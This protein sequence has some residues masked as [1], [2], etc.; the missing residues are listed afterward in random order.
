MPDPF[1]NP[2]L[3]PPPGPPPTTYGAAPEPYQPLTFDPYAQRQSYVLPPHST[4]P[5][6]GQSYISPPQHQQALH[7]EYTGYTNTGA[8]YG[9]PQPQPLYEGGYELHDG[10]E[11]H[12]MMDSGDMPLLR[13]PSGSR[14]P[15]GGMGMEEGDG[16]GGMPGGYDA[17][18]Q[19]E[20]TNIRYGRIPQ[21]VPR[22]YKTIKK[23]E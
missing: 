15:L 8:G 3:S 11:E 7:P 17:Q 4:S 12:E 2:S 13:A 6:T 20:D 19:E 21:R 22:R 23:V 9:D 18:S 16:E 1:A 14:P 5:P 10:G